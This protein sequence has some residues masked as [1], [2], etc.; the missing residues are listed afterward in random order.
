MSNLQKPS[1]VAFRKVLWLDGKESWRY[2]TL[3]SSEERSNELDERIVSDA[4]E[5]GDC[6]AVVLNRERSWVRGEVPSC[7]RSRW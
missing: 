7:P 4:V 3:R 1:E 5:R 6:V 2:S